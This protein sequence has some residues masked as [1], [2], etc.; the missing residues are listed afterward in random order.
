M[1]CASRR[2]TGTA[3][4]QARISFVRIIEQREP[5]S[6]RARQIEELS[7]ALDELPVP[8]RTLLGLLYGESCTFAEVALILEISE[9]E[10]REGHAAALADLFQTLAS[11]HE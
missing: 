11:G 1:V 7:L 8:T 10:V 3:L 9:A 6:E 2:N 5:D 4:A